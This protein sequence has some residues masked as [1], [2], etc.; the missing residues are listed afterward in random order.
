MKPTRQ[1]AKLADDINLSSRV[2]DGRMH[3]CPICG[4][5][6]CCVTGATVHLCEGCLRE[7]PKNTNRYVRQALELLTMEVEEASR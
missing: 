6:L 5:M 2:F 3:D 1:P 4:R 7:W